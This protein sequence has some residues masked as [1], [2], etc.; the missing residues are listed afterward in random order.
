VGPADPDYGVTEG[1]E[2]ADSQQQDGNED[3]I[4]Q[5]KHGFL[6]GDLVFQE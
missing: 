5:F 2:R 6:P 3:K 1:N 4:T